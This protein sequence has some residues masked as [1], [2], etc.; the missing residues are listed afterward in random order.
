MASWAVDDL[1]FGKSAANVTRWIE[2][3][4][5]EIMIAVSV[6]VVV[7]AIL[8]VLTAGAGATV[9]V[10]LTEAAVVETAV[11]AE[12]ATAAGIVRGGTTAQDLLRFGALDLPQNT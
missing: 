10:P 11:A 4:P 8:I 9:I 3:H 7:T 6:V 5:K 12:G 1:T 2:A